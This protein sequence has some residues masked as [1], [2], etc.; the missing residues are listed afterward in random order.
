M[1]RHHPAPYTSLPISSEIYNYLNTASFASGLELEIWEIGERAIR[2]WIARNAPDALSK[3]L[4]DGYQWKSVFLPNGTLLRTVYGGKNYHAM[5]ETDTVRHDG[6]AT[7]PS[8]FVNQAGGVHRNAWKA[9]WVLL[10]N[11]TTWLLAASLRQTKAR[12]RSRLA[13]GAHVLPTTAGSM[14]VHSRI[15]E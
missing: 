10:P 4:C 9:I 11:T 12:R 15:S 6:K 5:I 7:S 1:N 8:G 2:E 14:P 13:A 3:N